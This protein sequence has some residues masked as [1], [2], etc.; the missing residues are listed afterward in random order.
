MD[1]RFESLNIKLAKKVAMKHNIKLR[2]RKKEY[3]YNC[4]IFF[5]PDNVRIRVNNHKVTYTCLNCGKITRFNY[6]TKPYLNEKEN[7]NANKK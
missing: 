1:D 7:K 3:C 5:K 4:N 6:K 2:D